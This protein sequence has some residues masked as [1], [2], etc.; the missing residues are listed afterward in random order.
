MPKSAI[1]KMSLYYFILYSFIMTQGKRPADEEML[2]PQ[3]L[4]SLYSI[5]VTEFNFTTR[6]QQT[7]IYTHTMVTLDKQA[8]RVCAS[9]LPINKR[10]PIYIQQYSLVQ[11][12]VHLSNSCSWLLCATGDS[13]RLI[14]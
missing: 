12:P 11:M 8:S 5:L 14:L 3:V 2:K 9:I 1:Y 13:D 10:D 7:L 6:G 4:L